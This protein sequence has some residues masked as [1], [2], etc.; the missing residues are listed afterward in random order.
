MLSYFAGP[1]DELEAYFRLLQLQA[2]HLFDRPG[3]WEQVCAVA[4]A[5]LLHRRLSGRQ[6]RALAGAAFQ[7]AFS[8]AHAKTARAK[9]RLETHRVTVDPTQR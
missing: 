1:T 4:E 5:L 2:E 7:K 6:V 8:E 9:P 3:A